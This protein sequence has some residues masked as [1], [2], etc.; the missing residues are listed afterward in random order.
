[1]PSSLKKLNKADITTVPYAANKQWVLPYSCPSISNSYFNIFKGTF[2]TGTFSPDNYLTDPITNG[3]YETLIY[4]S[5][6]HMFYQSYT[7]LLN[8]S[9]LMLNADT[10]ESA[11]QQRPT[12]SYFNYNINPN[13]V[14]NFPTG[15]N[16]GIR[17]LSVNQD[18]YGSKILPTSFN[19]SSSA[20]SIAD[21]G[22]GNLIDYT[23]QNFTITD[24]SGLTNSY[25]YDDC[26]GG[27]VNGT[28][29][30]FSSYTFCATLG[31]LTFGG[32]TIINNGICSSPSNVHVGNVFYA[33]G[34]AVITNTDYQNMFPLPP[35]AINDV[36]TYTTS[37]TSAKII[38]ILSNDVSRSCALNTSS[39]VLYGDNS[40][41][42]TVNANGTITLNASASGNYD[43]YYTVNS[44]CSN[45]CSLTS[46]K[47]KVTTNVYQVDPPGCIGVEFYGNRGD[48]TFYYVLCGTSVTSSLTLS[49]TDNPVQACIEG[50]FGV[51][52]STDWQLIAGCFNECVS[53]TLTNLGPAAL[54]PNYID[55]SGNTIYAGPVISSGS[56]TFCALYDTVVVLSLS[57]I[58]LNYTLVNNGDCNTSTYEATIYASFVANTTN[59]TTASVYYSIDGGGSGSYTLLGNI[60]D[61]TCTNLGV[62]NVST[63]STIYTGIKSGSSHLSFGATSASACSGGFTTNLCGTVTPYSQSMNQN[64]SFSL[65]VKVDEG[66]VNICP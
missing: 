64:Q 21:D 46:N 19:L 35:I 16:A 32:G 65:F 23:C 13:L 43:V 15:A 50:T 66:I 18:I 6:N 27:N 12:A 10:Y 47:A 61:D 48:N 9:S 55:C 51:S 5:M 54:Y 38:N 30:A 26:D 4:D 33:H 39:V 22:N 41:Y 25:S 56:I 63:G 29:G 7:N 2:I 28:L 57:P 52:G 34:L 37:N 62:V 49:D 59:P 40:T 36:A 53:Y 44:L 24:T 1:M 45:S 14:K 8:T 20:Y 58:D 60:W 3:Q 42:Y 31:T 17:V 11:S